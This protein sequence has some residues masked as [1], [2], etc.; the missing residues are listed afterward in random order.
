MPPDYSDPFPRE[1]FRVAMEFLLD[2]PLSEAELDELARQAIIEG[3]RVFSELLI[4][5]M[6]KNR[7]TLHRQCYAV[8]NGK[9]FRKKTIFHSLAAIAAENSN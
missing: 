6:E 9:W 7:I 3:G 2:R 5:A 1:V 4:T 8:W